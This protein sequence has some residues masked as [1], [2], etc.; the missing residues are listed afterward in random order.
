M[1]LIDYKLELESAAKSMILVHN[2]NTLIKMIVRNIVN[3]VRLHHAGILLYDKERN[4]YILTISRGQRGLKIPAGFARVESEKGLI[5]F[6]RNRDNY[7]GLKDTILT[8]ERIN[9]FLKKSFVSRHKHLK[10]TIIEARHQM[11]GF[12]AVVALPIFFQQDLLGV[13]LLGKKRSGKRFLQDELNF[14]VAL[15]NNVSMAIKNAELFEN[16]QFEVDRNH[17]LFIHTA[18]AMTAAIDAKDHYTHG[19][20]QRVTEYSLA[21]AKK[22]I[23]KR[24][25]SSADNFVENL[26]IAGLLHDIGKIGVPESILGKKG[27]L[28]AE[29]LDKIKQHAIIGVTILQPIKELGEPILGV[30]YHHENFDGTGYPEGKRGSDIPLPARIIR[31]ADA[32]DAMTSDRPYRLSLSKYEAIEELKKF[33]GIQ[34]DPVIVEATIDLYKEGSL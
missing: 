22:L 30:K 18:I 16:L 3:K 5:K 6:F 26:R 8:N 20:T 34:F 12:G 25:I 17:R 11:L 32:Y 9:V 2:H 33:S 10:N 29:E 7:E 15:S 23:A 28:D 4:S 13:M 21:I 14:F 27:K 19:H 1:G 24:K 31:I